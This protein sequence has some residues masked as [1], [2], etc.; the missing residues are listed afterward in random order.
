ML[1]GWVRKLVALAMGLW[2]S[3]VLGQN[4]GPVVGEAMSRPELPVEGQVLPAPVVPPRISYQPPVRDISAPTSPDMTLPP[5]TAVATPKMNPRQIRFTPRYG[6]PIILNSVVLADGTRRTVF[7]GGVILNIIGESPQQQ[8]AKEQ[9]L[10]LNPTPTK[11]PQG[12][13]PQSGSPNAAPGSPN[14]APGSP[15]ASPARNQNADD[16]ELAADEIVIWSRGLDMDDKFQPIGNQPSPGGKNSYEVYLSGNVIIRTRP[17]VGPLQTL[18]GSQIYYDVDRERAIALSA[19]FEYRPLL[20]VP[21]GGTVLAPDPFHFKAQEIRKLD[22]ENYEGLNASFNSSKLP[23][24]PGLN[25]EA[26]RMT[27]TDRYVQLR[28]FFGIPYR[29]LLTGKPVVGEE[30]IITAY[31]AVPYLEGIPLFYFPYYRGNADEPLGPFMTLSGGENRVFGAQIYTTWNMFELLALKPPPDQTHKW[32]LNLDYLSERGFGFG[33]DYKYHIPPTDPQ[34]GLY[35]VDGLI[36]YYG[37]KDHGL[38]QLGGDR[39]PEPIQ[40]DFRDHFLWRHTQDFS[41]D[42]FFQGQ[43][44]YVSDKNFMEQYY[45]QD[46]DLGPKPGDLRQLD[47]AAK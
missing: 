20:P 29:E 39:G 11:G 28:N 23:S 14:G 2:C 38:D 26:P 7:T 18:R 22:A 5:G 13:G 10:N 42:L 36:Q 46:W 37:I 17:A 25:L 6:T 31:G 24:D 30:K 8:P 40:P 45:K 35:G 1:R 3:S 32:T 27:L 47:V 34:S 9:P 21:G 44:T 16:T 33:S 15:N 41:P 43:L 12:N 19:E 4:T